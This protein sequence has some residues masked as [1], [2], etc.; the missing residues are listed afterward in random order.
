MPLGSTP[1][2]YPGWPGMTGRLPGAGG[3]HDGVVDV[4][5]LLLTGGSSRRMGQDKATLR[6]AG[7]SLAARTAGVLRAARL[8][9]PLLEVGPGWSG[10]AALPDDLPGTGPL[11]AVAAGAAALRRCGFA[12]GA[13]VVATDLPRLAPEL[14]SWLALHPA[15][16]SVVPL[17]SGRPQWLCARYSPEDLG[18]AAELV[19]SGRR[20]ISCLAG[21]GVHL[22]GEDELVGASLRPEDLDDADTP[23]ELARCLGTR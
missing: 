9:G 2:F 23:D 3:G 12:G 18:S 19:G 21:P 6:I 8:P 13:L 5:A 22:A 11:A 10:L 4:G 16:G 7:T 15:P 17:R 20:A 14:V 1:K